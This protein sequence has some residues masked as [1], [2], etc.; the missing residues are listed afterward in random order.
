[1]RG[2][3]I[4]PMMNQTNNRMKKDP[5]AATA[6]TTERDAYIVPDIS[7]LE[8]SSQTPLCLSGDNE[9]YVWEHLNW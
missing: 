7:V 4:Y 8:T 2:S 3:S 9:N 6:A 5:S 1:M